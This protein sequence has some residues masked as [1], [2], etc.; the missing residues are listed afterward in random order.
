MEAADTKVLET[1]ATGFVGKSVCRRLIAAGYAIKT[2]V[3]E[4]SRSTS[5]PQAS[6]LELCFG[7]LDDLASLNLAC[8]EVD[9]VVHLAGIDPLTTL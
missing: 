8:S 2:L 5:L 6:N 3:R 7:D 9:V 1:G 4:Q